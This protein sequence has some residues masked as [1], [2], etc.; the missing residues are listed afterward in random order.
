MLSLTA[1]VGIIG[2]DMMGTEEKEEVV[3]VNFGHLVF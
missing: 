2:D 1:N 3:T